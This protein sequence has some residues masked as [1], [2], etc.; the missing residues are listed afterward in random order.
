MTN[1]IAGLG[2]RQDR[3]R[4]TAAPSGV[5]FTNI[6]SCKRGTE[7]AMKNAGLY[8]DTS[9]F[10]VCSPVFFI[11]A[12]VPRLQLRIFVKFTPNGY[13][14]ETPQQYIPATTCMHEMF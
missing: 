11:A 4:Q 14:S 5:N 1:Q 6:R 8:N 2:K 7:A 3:G 12:S 10:V 9:G 13:C